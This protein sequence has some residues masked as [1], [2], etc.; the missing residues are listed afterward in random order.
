MSFDYKRL[1]LPNQ[2]MKSTEL[3]MSRLLSI[4]VIFK[5]LISSLYNIEKFSYRLKID[6]QIN[7][8]HGLGVE[9]FVILYEQNKR[10]V[11]NQFPANRSFAVFESCFDSFRFSMPIVGALEL[12]ILR[13]LRNE[14]VSRKEVRKVI[15]S[16]LCAHNLNIL[17]TTSKSIEKRVVQQ[18]ILDIANELKIEF[19]IIDLDVLDVN[20]LSIY[21]LKLIIPETGKRKA[22]THV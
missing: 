4:F 18:L 12:L 22:K 14:I 15:E 11:W 16:V 3:G 7:V 19:L 5:T 21:D 17:R 8:L 6:Q 1:V 20:K 10:N 9:D 2:T 13:G